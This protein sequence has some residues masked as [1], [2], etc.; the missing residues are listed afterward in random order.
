MR[1]LEML[2]IRF[3]SPLPSYSLQSR[4]LDTLIMTRVTL[5]SLRQFVIS[6]LS[7]YLEDLLAQIN[8]PALSR[9]TS[10]IPHVL[11]LLGT[12]HNLGFSTF[13]LDF[14]FLETDRYGHGDEHPSVC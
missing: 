13:L 10:T 14:F 3:R 4:S 1:S 8:T 9:L 6:G 2:A 12:S 5:S 7:P 11:R